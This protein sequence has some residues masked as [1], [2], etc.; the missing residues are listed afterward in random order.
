MDCFQPREIRLPDG[1]LQV[2]RCNRCLACLSHRQAEWIT[3]LRVEL[4]DH[5][6]SSYFVTLTYDEEHLP[7]NTAKFDGDGYSFLDKVPSVRKRDIIS[8]HMDLRKRFQQGFYN[9][10]TLK[11]NGFGEV[12][13]IPLPDCHFTFYLTSEYGPEGHRPHYHGLYFGLPEDNDLTFDL[14]TA[15]WKRGFTFIEP[16]A[17]DKAAAYVAKYLVNTSLVPVSVHADR[18]FALMSKGLGKGYLS[19]SRIEWHREDYLRRLYVPEHGTR[20]VLPRYLRDKIL[21]DGMRADI[22]EESLNREEAKEQAFSLLD[23]VEQALRE[24]ETTLP[25]SGH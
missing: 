18:P 9:D 17:S 5:P 13:R 4:E 1:R 10:D 12:Q 3:R 21:D 22:L 8:F 20:Q 2:V 14:M 11:R 24:R 15:I 19:P 23:P 16:A 6:T 7:V 25:N